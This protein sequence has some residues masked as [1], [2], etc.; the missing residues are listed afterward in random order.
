MEIR[1][2]SRI[3]VS[4]VIP[5][6]NAAKTIAETLESLL[7][8]TFTNWEA[9][10][11]DDGSDDG[12]AAVAGSFGKK[13]HRIRIVSQQKSGVSAARNTGIR[14]ASFDWLLFLDADDWIVPQYFERM[15][16]MLASNPGLDA[17]YCRWARVA[18]DGTYAGE[19]FCLQTGDMFSTFAQRAVF[20][21]H[22]C[23]I[24]R[25]LVM[26]VGE[27]DTSLRTCED[28]DLWQ[29]IARTGAQF[30]AIDEVFAL[31]RMQPASASIDGFQMFADG[32]RVLRQGHAP[33][34][35]VKNPH[36]AH[37]NGL[38]VEQIE[39]Q[40]FYFSCWCAGLIMG[41]GK[42]ARQ[43]L[44]SLKEYSYPQLDPHG[45]AKIIFQ[46]TPLPACH[47]PAVWVELWPAVE[48]HIR[49]FLVALEKQAQA[50]ALIQRTITTLEHLIL[51]HPMVLLPPTIGNLHAIRIEVTEPISGIL[52]PLSV[53]RLNCTVELEGTCI[54]AFDLPVCDGMVSRHVLADA[55]ATDFY[56]KILGHFFE[57]TVYRD[58]KIRKEQS[59]LSLWRGDICIAD[60]LPEN[61]P[62]LWQQM[63]N[64]IGWTVFLQEIWGCRNKPQDYFYSTQWTEAGGKKLLQNIL[65]CWLLLQAL[66]SQLKG[67]VQRG[68]SKGFPTVEVSKRLSDLVVSVKGNNILLTVGGAALGVITLP[69]RGSIVSTQELR[70]AITD[71]GGTELCRVAVREGLLGRPMTDQ[72]FTLRAR[73]AEAAATAVQRNRKGFVAE[74][75]FPSQKRGNRDS[76]F[77][78]E[79]TKA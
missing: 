15:T 12:T 68:T 35:R 23:I 56:W 60:N 44:H 72:S 3:N 34:V 42:D 75:Y 9:I 54:G 43:L 36:P 6:H 69:V 53:E 39:K 66:F 17:V 73:L 33:D 38:P 8:Q 30:G 24:R 74:K 63:H 40:I 57:H 45:I 32:L 49:D 29:R 14:L 31:Y 77:L 62:V 41:C 13:D 5:A 26:A 50:P 2:K 21:I 70:A 28:W 37:A 27:F 48:Q 59:G 51:G 67:V 78:C 25:S 79:I 47:T 18:H 64:R 4:V 20:P 19:D 65:R 58:L 16:H 76:F 22:A 52:L 11:I 46:A 10:V 55:I 71:A 7:A 1:H 61:E